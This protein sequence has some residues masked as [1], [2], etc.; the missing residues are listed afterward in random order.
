MANLNKTVVSQYENLKGVD[1]SS[2]PSLVDKNRSPY[3]LNLM[4]DASF[5]PVKRPGWETLFT[6]DEPI[7]NLW[8]CNL[9]GKK[10][11]LCH[12]GDSIYLLND[13]H[14]V[15]L[16]N[17]LSR[18]KGCGFYALKGEKGGFYILTSGEYLCF[19]G[20]TDIIDVAQ[21]AY[22]P[23]T[24]IAKSPSGDGESYEDINC[25]TGDRRENFIGTETDLIYQLGTDDI[26]EVKIIEVMQQNGTHRLLA[27]NVDYTV[28]LTLGRITFTQPYPSPVTG[29]DNIFVTYTKNI[30]GYKEKITKCTVAALFGLGG[31]NR[32]FLSGNPDCP[33]KDFWSGVFDPTYFSDLCYAV[34]GSGQTAVMGY[35]KM[36]EKLGIVKEGNGQDTSLFLRTAQ[37]DGDDALFTVQGGISGFGA[38]SKNCFALLND[39]P[40]FLSSRGIFAVTNSLVTSEKIIVNRSYQIDA[41]LT[42]E[43]GL[44]KAVACV[45]KDFYILSV[46]GNCYL[47]D[48]RQVVAAKNGEKSSRYEAYFWNNVFAS[49]FA[50]EGDVLWFGT[51]EGQVRRFRTNEE[52]DECYSDDGAAIYAVWETP[53]E[54]E[55]YIERFKTLQRKGCLVTLKPY[56]TSSCNIYYSADGGV[57]RLIRTGYVDITQAFEKVNFARFAFSTSSA[58]QEIYFYSRCKRYKRIQLIFENGKVNEGF[59]IQKIVKT[60]KIN[61]HSENRR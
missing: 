29:H 15:L 45:W 10:Q 43:N 21:E 28:D 39:E 52:E 3:C 25:L 50:A 49:C 26:E 60:Y 20:G 57:R 48:S 36:G 53:M 51:E 32:V 23:L 7:Y 19:K 22:V 9:N 2:P 13:N 59:G 54:D 11:Y 42:K 44:E 34:I 5:N 31:E 1:F 30:E 8:I 61:T 40:L 33:H 27:E 37:P 55:G 14:K 56:R 58:P 18:G 6:F 41:R 35:L 24:A 12:A 4:P 16:K 47:L 46:N 17:G 38:V